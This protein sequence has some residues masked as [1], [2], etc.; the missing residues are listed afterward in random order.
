[1][2]E[3]FKVSTTKSLYK[4]IEIE[5]DGKVYSRP[6]I[7]VS[8]LQQVE[9]L[10]RKVAKGDTKSFDALIEQLH[11]LTGVPKPV[12]KEID[13]RDIEKMMEYLSAKLYGSSTKGEEKKGSTP[14]PKGSS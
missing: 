8:L 5:V 7:T 9:A 1:M 11:L 14:G 12:A 10:E 3:R 13:L 4:P 2:T 6:L